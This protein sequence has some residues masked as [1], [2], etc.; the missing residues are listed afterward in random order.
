[1]ASTRKQQQV[2]VD[3]AS[4]LTIFLDNRK[5]LQAFLCHVLRLYFIMSMKKRTSICGSHR[6]ESFSLL[7]PWFY[8]FPHRFHLEKKNAN[9]KYKIVLK[10]SKYQKYLITQHLIIQQ[11]FLVIANMAKVHLFTVCFRSNLVSD[12]LILFIFTVMCLFCKDY[13]V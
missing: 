7:S 6:L 11:D 13:F 1:M 5:P 2:L 3:Q 9:F 4:S 10:S 8:L 12:G